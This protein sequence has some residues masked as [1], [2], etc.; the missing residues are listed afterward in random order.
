MPQSKLV[1]SRNEK[2]NRRQRTIKNANLDKIS[3]SPFVADIGTS[4]GENYFKELVDVIY[5]IRSGKSVDGTYTSYGA[6]VLVPIEPLERF[7]DVRLHF[8]DNVTLYE[9]NVQPHPNM[10]SLTYYVNYQLL[11]SYI[12]LLKQ[13]KKGACLIKIILYDTP[14]KKVDFGLQYNDTAI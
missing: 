8:V 1:Q 7:V 4:G 6:I 10:K 13:T 9:N 5:H 14:D 3:Y 11:P 12:S 2:D